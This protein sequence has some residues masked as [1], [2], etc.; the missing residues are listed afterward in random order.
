MFSQKTKREKL[1]AK[2]RKAREARRYKLNHGGFNRWQM[3]LFYT[4][5]AVVGGAVYFAFIYSVLS[6]GV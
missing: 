5:F 3:G 2:Q 4:L 1:R 6:V